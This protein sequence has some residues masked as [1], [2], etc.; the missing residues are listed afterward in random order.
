ML[1]YLESAM[2]HRNM[3]VGVRCSS[4]LVIE[5]TVGELDKRQTRRSR[6]VTLVE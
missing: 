1:A 6:G 5:S 3:E 2:T 4:W